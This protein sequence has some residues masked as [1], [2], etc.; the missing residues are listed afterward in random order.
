MD[1]L[2][3]IATEAA[4]QCGRLTVPEIDNPQ[5]LKTVLSDWKSDRGLIWLDETG[6]GAPIADVITAREKGEPDALL[7]GPEGGFSQAELSL[8]GKKV[9][10]TPTSMGNRLLRAETACIAA[11]S[12]WQALAGDWQDARPVGFDTI[13]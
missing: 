3:A 1:R 2:Y 6:S 5:T 8:I 9:Y 7:I 4:E 10:V 13:L 11:L 12:T